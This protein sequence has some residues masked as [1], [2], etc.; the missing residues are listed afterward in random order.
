MFYDESW[1]YVVIALAITIVF[2][3]LCFMV[4]ATCKFDLLTDLAGSMN[5]VALAIISLCVRGVYSSRQIALTVIVM[6]IRLELAVFL[7]VRVC[8]R[9]KDARFD[10]TRENCCKFLAFWIGQMMWVWVCCGCRVP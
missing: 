9:K 5:F 2:Q 4:A 7:L 6:A 3:L 1:F 8:V 10:S